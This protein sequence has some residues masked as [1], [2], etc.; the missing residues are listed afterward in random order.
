VRVALVGD[1]YYPDIG[2][3]SHYAFELSRHLVKLGVETVV[4]THW[5]PG[6][7]EEEQFAGVKGET[8]QRSG[9]QGSPPCRLTTCLP[10]LPQIHPR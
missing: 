1:E 4:I 8:R 5:H 6:Q 10:S 7:P 2:G 3:A 9:A